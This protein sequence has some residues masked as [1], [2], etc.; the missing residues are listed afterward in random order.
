VHSSRSRLADRKPL[1]CLAVL[2]AGLTVAGLTGCASL[3]TT[4]HCST[5]RACSTAGFGKFG[6]AI[7]TPRGATFVTGS[8]NNGVLEIDFRDRESGRA[9]KEFVGRP[10]GTKAACPGTVVTLSSAR[11]FCYGSTT[12]GLL[13]QFT[14]GKLLYTVSFT[15]PPSDA[16]SDQAAVS[17]IVS[18]LS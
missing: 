14:S 1:L 3:S 15:V 2:L 16:A 13:A 11:R 5:V 7:L 12:T 10:K 4:E 9:Y 8:I 17:R 18:S 6:Q